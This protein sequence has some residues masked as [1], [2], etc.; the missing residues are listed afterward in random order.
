MEGK[1]ISDTL[2]RKDFSYE[3]IHNQELINYAKSHL[4]NYGILRKE[5]EHSYHYLKIHDDF[6]FKLFPYLKDQNLRMP[7]YF[8]PKNF[9]G[10]HITLF[11]PDE[12]T[13]S[14]KVSLS[15]IKEINDSYSFEVTQIISVHAFHKR[16]VALVVEASALL[17]LR[18][19]YG[20][21]EKL[22]YHGLLVPFHI[23]IAI[24]K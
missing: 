9:V 7:D 16:F 4:P 13:A 1:L 21:Q 11:Y 19:F 12:I 15:N 10:A 22:N 6:I 2:N 8:P 20:L 23:T 18:K 14:N 3:I 24:N 5:D 17:A